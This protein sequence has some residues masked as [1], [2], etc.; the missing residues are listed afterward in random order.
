MAT[1]IW[2]HSAYGKR[3]AIYS[4]ESLLKNEGHNV[5]APDLYQG[6][7]VFDNEDAAIRYAYSLG[8]LEVSFKKNILLQ[9]LWEYVVRE[10]ERIGPAVWAGWS[11][12]ALL[13]Q[14][15]AQHLAKDRDPKLRPTGLLL[16]GKEL[17][18]RYEYKP[19]P[20][21]RVHIHAAKPDDFVNEKVLTDL[22]KRGA[23]VIRYPGVGHIF[24]DRL[25]RD[26]NA[27][28]TATWWRH[29][30]EFLPPP[31]GRRAPLESG[32]QAAG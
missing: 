4:Q 1:V 31:P 16:M 9:R 17:E 24:A 11:I 27:A 26:F 22:E 32:D 6:Q 19:A 12:G 3:P 20:L 8:I 5:H 21:D 13:A 18:P 10:R 28:A 14:R 15:M 29:V 25:L 7:G 30:K 2:L 23:K